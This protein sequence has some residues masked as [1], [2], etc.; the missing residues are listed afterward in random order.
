[1][2]SFGNGFGFER[3][4]TPFSDW[5][6]RDCTVFNK[7]SKEEK[8]IQYAA[9]K[10]FD[11][12]PYIRRLLFCFQEGVRKNQIG[13]IAVDLAREWMSMD[14]PH[15]D[16]WAVE[17]QSI[18]YI[19]NRVVEKIERILAKPEFL[20]VNLLINPD[21]N[22]ENPN[23][24]NPLSTD[25]EAPLITI[26]SEYAWMWLPCYMVENGLQKPT[27]V[28]DQQKMIDF[29]AE[30]MRNQGDSEEAI[31]AMRMKQK[32]END[33]AYNPARINEQRYVDLLY[34]TFLESNGAGINQII[35]EVGAELGK[36]I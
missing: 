21:W 8:E 22:Y 5:I 26:M 23:T 34:S 16:D 36:V 35:E 19:L 3:S 20:R 6:E 27:D 25:A 10:N 32:R 12:N 13:G 7:L 4:N 29:V 1:M 24:D 28:V 9:E 15:E 30:I 11:I 14:V 2:R 17:V 18:E 33:T 31:E